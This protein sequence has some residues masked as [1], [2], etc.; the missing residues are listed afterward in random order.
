MNHSICLKNLY[1]INNPITVSPIYGELI[2]TDA[3]HYSYY[4]I[5]KICLALELFT[6][7]QLLDNKTRTNISDI[8]AIKNDDSNKD[9]QILN[10]FLIVKRN[11]FSSKYDRLTSIELLQMLILLDSSEDLIYS[12]TYPLPGFETENNTNKDY[13]E[14]KILH[15]MYSCVRIYCDR[16]E[17]TLSCGSN[18]KPTSHSAN[19]SGFNLNYY[20]EYNSRLSSYLS[21]VRTSSQNE[22]LSVPPTTRS[23]YHHEI[24]Q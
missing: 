16:N 18:N 24:N 8:D 2:S 20:Y 15:E 10:V 5:L 23:K 12:I 3:R 13:Q 14:M 7:F 1:K 6:Q 22:A 9:Y 17:S 21:K 19:R 4:Y 11:L